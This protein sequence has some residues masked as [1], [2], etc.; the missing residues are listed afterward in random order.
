M[1]TPAPDT[2]P[3]VLTVAGSDSGGGAGVQAVNCVSKGGE[4]YFH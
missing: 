2:R 4:D 3:V 1:R